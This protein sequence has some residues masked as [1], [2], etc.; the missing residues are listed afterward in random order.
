[1]KKITIRVAISATL[2]AVS[3]AGAGEFDGGYVGVKAGTNRSSFSGLTSVNGGALSNVNVN[4]RSGTTFGIEGGYNWDKESYLLGVDGFVD[5]N[6]RENSS[7]TINGV[8]GLVDYGS[9]VY[10]LNFKLGLPRGNWL[11]YAKLGYASGRTDSSLNVEGSGAHGGLGVAYKFAPNWS[12]AGEFTGHTADSS[13]K[14]LKN[15]NFTVGLNYHFSSPPKAVPVAVPEPVVVKAPEP[16]VVKA[17]EPVVEKAPEP[18]AP[19]PVPQIKESWRIIK[20]QKPVT[21]EGANFDFDSAKLRPAAN[22]KLQPVVEFAIKYP[23]AGLDVHGHTDGI[24]SPAYNQKLS[25]RRAASVKAYL[26][27]KGIDA[28]RIVTKG[29]GETQHIADEKTKAGRA[30]N[31]RVEIHYTIIDEKKV[32]VTE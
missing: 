3:S 24:G 30:K 29:F 26:V 14:K 11:P 15:D 9:S 8:A 4:D 22:A 16:V 5:H 28:G 31:R 2:L 20:E 7:G 13:G 25:E 32:R 27:K 12:I 1:M 6:S 19:E 23:E 17:P 18:P 10:G 21:I